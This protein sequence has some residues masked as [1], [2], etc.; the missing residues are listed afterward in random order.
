MELSAAS[1]NVIRAFDVTLRGTMRRLGVNVT[2]IGAVLRE[3][4]GGGYDVL[5]TK[6]KGDRH[7]LRQVYQV[8]LEGEPRSFQHDDERVFLWCC[9]RAGG[10]RAMVST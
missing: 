9:K 6:S 7:S 1:M 8:R 10:G 3:Q 2:L 5:F 4:A